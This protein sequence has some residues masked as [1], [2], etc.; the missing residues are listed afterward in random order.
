MPTK[1]VNLTSHYNQFIEKE[2]NGGYYNNA[3]E[4]IRAG[5][6]L[7]ERQELQEQAK[8]K[9]LQ[10]AAR[11]GFKGVDDGNYVKINSEQELGHF[12]SEIEDD[13]K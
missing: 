12:F 3:S 6:H 2:I 7:L 8:L 1:N 13:V 4:V 9:A 10:E 11:I 5:L